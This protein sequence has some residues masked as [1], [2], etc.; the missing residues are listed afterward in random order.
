MTKI[1]KVRKTVPFRIDEILYEKIRFIAE[2]NYRSVN[3]EIELLVEKHVADFETKNNI[4]PI[5]LDDVVEE[6]K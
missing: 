6:D 3:A 4:I 5:N 1:S 2:Q